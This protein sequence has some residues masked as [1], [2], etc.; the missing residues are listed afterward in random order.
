MKK[1]LY[2]SVLIINGAAH[3]IL[4]QVTWNQLPLT[5][6]EAKIISA[7]RQPRFNINLIISF[8]QGDVAPQNIA[9]PA[10]QQ[11][12]F[13]PETAVQLFEKLGGEFMIGFTSGPQEQTVA[14]PGRIQISPG[15][16]AGVRIGRR[17]EVRVSAQHF[18]SEWSG[19]FPVV[20]IPFQ[21]EHPLPPKTLQGSMNTSVSAIGGNL[22]TAFFVTRGTIRPYISAGIRGIFPVQTHSGAEIAGVAL[23]LKIDTGEA[24]FSLAGGAGV[25]WNF[26]KNAFFDAGWSIAELPDGDYH[27]VAGASV[28]W[29]F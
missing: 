27:Q 18:Q 14:L 1:S 25:R 29:S 23:P 26:W 28:G 13:A 12:A 21:Q 16:Q 3:S 9:I 6:A 4:G 5:G 2:I 22:G 19:V 7:V 15:L 11:A 10:L 8:P 24:S 20:V 17:F